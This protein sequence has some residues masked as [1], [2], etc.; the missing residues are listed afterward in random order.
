MRPIYLTFDCY[1]T[2][3]NWKSGVLN[4]LRD[5]PK[6]DPDVFF[7]TWWRVDRRLTGGRPYR[8][9]REILAQNFTEAFRSVGVTIAG[10]EAKRLADNLGNWKPFPDVPDVLA[11]FK[12]LG[13][14]LGILSNID[15]DLLA[16]SVDQ[17]GVDIDVRITAENIRSYKPKTGHFEA[18]LEMAGLQE[19]QVLH[20]AASRFVDI[21]PASKFGFRTMYVRRSEPDADHNVVPEFTVETL[22]DA[23]PILENL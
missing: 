8:R 17:F 6:I 7:E 15:N 11:G 22:T 14:K 21:E 9:Y 1:G 12:Q 4:A 5:Y 16:R 20:I 19:V 10:K 18:L 23:I 2:L 3:I 13:F